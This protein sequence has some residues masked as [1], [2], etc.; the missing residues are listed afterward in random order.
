MYSNSHHQRDVVTTAGQEAASA[1]GAGVTA[2]QPG[3][4]NGCGGDEKGVRADPAR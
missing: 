1:G 2:Q 3:Q 4:R